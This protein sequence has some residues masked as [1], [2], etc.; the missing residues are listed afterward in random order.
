MKQRKPNL[1]Y[2]FCVGTT[3]KHVGEGKIEG[4][5]RGGRKC[6]EQPDDL[7]DRK[8]HQYFKEEELDPS[9]WRTHFGRSCGPVARQTIK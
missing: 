7:K 8:R 9:I 1:I 4:K 2:I 3:S 6:K 5:G